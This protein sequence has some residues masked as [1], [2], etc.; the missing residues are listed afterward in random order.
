MR[1]LNI[2]CSLILILTVG[3]F[4]VYIYRLYKNSDKEGPVITIENE[5]IE[6]SVRDGFDTFLEGVTAYD[7]T[8]GDVT[9]TLGIESISGF[10]DKECTTRQINYVAFD[11]NSHVAK[12]SRRMVYSDYRPIHFA[13]A[14]PLKFPEQSTN[15][16]ILGV[17]RAWDCLDGDISR[18]IVFSEDSMV[19]VDTAGAYDVVLC[20]TNSAGDTEEL[21]VTI[22]I[23][24]KEKEGALP[25][26]TLKKY[27]VYTNVG[28]KINPYD[29]IQ[30]VTYSGVE[31]LVTN[32]EGTFAIDTSDWTPEQK[33][34]FL[35]MDP[36]V[37]INKF[38]IT[39]SVDYNTPGSYE[40]KYTID[41][42]TG[43]RGY[44]Y[45]IV[46]VE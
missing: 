6:V 34:A 32:G 5:T 13:L 15:V 39:D 4:G 31:Y 26:I 7:E 18:Q 40:I 24:E 9:Y 16:N 35:K 3:F 36:K 2:V 46:V 11:S 41:T 37:D 25:Q 12:A 1:I 22:R 44:V 28:K 43:E 38:K 33:K 27:L 30:S 29:Y 8:D 42:L 17:T 21:P 19:Q 10:I 45:L 14:S 20:V 23:Y